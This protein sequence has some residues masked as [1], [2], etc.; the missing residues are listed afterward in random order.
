MKKATLYVDE[1]FKNNRIFDVSSPIINRDNAIAPYLK[2]KTEFLK[3][4]IDLSTQ[5]INSIESSIFTIYLDVP[6]EIQ[7]SNVNNSFLVL[8]EPIVIKPDNWNIY[9]HRFFNKIFT[10]NDDFTN[11]L[12]YVKINFPYTFPT[13][14]DIVYSPRS[15][16]CTLISSNKSSSHSMELYSERLKAI[17]WFEKYQPDYFKF[18]GMNWNN[19]ITFKRLVKSFLNFNF[20]DLKKY[21]SYCG[22]INSKS[23]VLSNFRFSICY[24]N[25][26]GVSGYITEKIFDCFVAGVIPIYL[27]ASNIHDFIPESSFIDKRKFNNYR[28][29]FSF[30]NN[31]SESQIKHYLDSINSFLNSNKIKDFSDDTFS[32]TL[33][34]HILK[35]YDF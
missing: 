6:K 25:M 11:N 4:N 5:D 22:R 1:F 7:L 34:S 18:Y 27:G 17:N 3:Y 28:D 12:K 32:H 19:P 13:K 15:D 10:W 20:D 9:N 30:L 33:I 21:K 24:E 35:Y 26:S 31:L 2:L 16:F 8:L 23:E 29:L 14:K